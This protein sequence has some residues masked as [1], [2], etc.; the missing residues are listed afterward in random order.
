MCHGCKSWIGPSVLDCDKSTLAA[1][2]I[3]SLEAGADYLHLDVMDGSFVPNISFGPQVIINLRTH[4]P[5]TFF[6]NHMMVAHPENFITQVAEANATH[7]VTG[8][9]LNQF[10]FHIE[11][12][13]GR[14]MTQEVID[15][16]KKAGMLVGIALSPA[17]PIETV[18][19]YTDQLDCVLVMTVVPG[20]GGQSFNLDMMAKVSMVRELYPKIDIE[21]DGGLK[22]ATIDHAARAG[23]NMIVSGSGVFKAEDMAFNISTMQRSLQKYGNCLPDDKLSPLKYDKQVF[24]A[25]F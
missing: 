7:P 9:N 10:T 4:T 14:G 16:C 1:E 8:A 20:L 22:P 12:T 18:L 6:D 2:S 17:T 23:A 11:A 13:E 21:V 24:A 15:G 19:K 25:K 5:K 3:R